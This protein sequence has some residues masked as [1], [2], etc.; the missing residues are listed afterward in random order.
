VEWGMEL[1]GE[2]MMELELVSILVIL[3]KIEQQL[4]DKSDI[5][6]TVA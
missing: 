3:D 6:A 2:V 1:I 4:F 5:Q